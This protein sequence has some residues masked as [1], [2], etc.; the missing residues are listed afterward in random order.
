MA[1]E[2]VFRRNVTNPTTA[3][4]VLQIVAAAAMP[5]TIIRAQVTQRDSATSAQLGWQLA[6]LSAAATVTIA[7]LGTDILK[8]DPGDANSVVQ[9]G[10]S[11]TGYSASTAGTQ[12]EIPFAEGWNTLSGAYWTALPEERITVPGGGIFGLFLTGTVP[13]GVYEAVIVYAEGITG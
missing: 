2:Y 7:V 8:A 1:R 11:L 13:A 5:I 3:R 4:A 6:R 12:G 9:L 10:T